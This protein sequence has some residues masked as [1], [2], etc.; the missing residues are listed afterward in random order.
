M[1]TDVRDELV[2]EALE[3]SVRRVVPDP[4]VRL[5]SIVRKGARRHA[6]RT[7]SMVMAVLVF[8][9]AIGWTSLQLRD[10]GEGVAQVGSL[11]QE[12]FTLS[13]PRGWD[14]AAIGGCGFGPLLAG[15]VVSN[16][17]FTFRNPSGE[18]PRCG[19]RLVLAGFPRDGVAVSL[20]P[21]GMRSGLIVARA[22]PFPMSLNLLQPTHG[23][24]GGPT[25]SFLSVIV[26]G[27][28][29]GLLNTFVGP[30]APD[31]ARRAVASVVRSIRVAGVP[32]WVTARDDAGDATVRYPQ[33]W[34]PAG[35]R[36]TPSLTD[37]SEILALGTYPLRPGGENCAQFPV[38]AI[39][40]LGPTDALIWIGE[41]REVSAAVDPL[42]DE[43][44]LLAG[45]SEG[46]DDSRG[47]LSTPKDFWHRYVEFSEAG[48]TFDLYIAHGNDAPGATLSE[49]AG[50]LHSLE[51][52]AN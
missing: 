36:L 15:T 38:N 5:P 44:Q 28:V 26:D 50:I 22:T 32:D 31:G 11:E 48:R 45:P 10:D 6:G 13:V 25:M 7:A 41:R 40:D 29:V 42:P 8:V 46:D 30:E 49:M 2:R 43:F 34:M 9:S 20:T 33:G 24:N 3:R 1:K 51:F 19:D 12:G 52:D 23:I 16:V 27:E 47:C 4:Q 37:P 14:V 17:P 21:Q 18:E 39:E 35:Q